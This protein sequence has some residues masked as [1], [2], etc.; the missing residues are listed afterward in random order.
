MVVFVGCSK[1]ESPEQSETTKTQSVS[2]SVV[3]DQQA[4]NKFPNTFTP[5]T[6]EEKIIFKN[7]DFEDLG[8]QAATAFLYQ[9]CKILRAWKLGT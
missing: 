6:D 3:E 5:W 2:E 4:E 9:A 7:M 8:K 1:A